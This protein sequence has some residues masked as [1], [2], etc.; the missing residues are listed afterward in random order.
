MSCVTAVQVLR[1]SGEAGPR[2]HELAPRLACSHVEFICGQSPDQLAHF[3]PSFVPI[4]K[5]GN[6]EEAFKTYYEQ[7]CYSRGKNTDRRAAC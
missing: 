5:I 3:A 6:E 1:S 2:R 7:H 4:A